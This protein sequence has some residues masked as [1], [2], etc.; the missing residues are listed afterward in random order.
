MDPGEDCDD[1]AANSDNAFCTVDCRLNTCGDGLVFVGWELCDQGEANSDSYGSA[2]TTTYTPGARCG[3]H[4]VQLE[5]ECDLGVDN[6]GQLGD[7]QGVLC[8][9]SCD[10]LALRT[11]VTSQVFSGNL[12]GI[13][14]ADKR[15]RD[16][17]MAAGLPESFSFHAY[18]STPDS[19]ANKRFPGAL[20]V[21]MP[22]VLVTGKKVADS[23]AKLL[24]EG[25]T[26]NGISWPG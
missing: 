23:H 3:D 18:L 7:E 21:P 19:P 4:I 14:G 16:A 22:Y 13:D 2:C 25:P 5:E 17:A 24:A 9:A 1:G 15:C 6:G 26:P 8:D 12:G 20:A 10:A 11:F